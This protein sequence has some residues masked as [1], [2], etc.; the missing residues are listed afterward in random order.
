MRT[1]VLWD[2]DYTLL[3]CD[4]MGREAHEAAFARV[5]GRAPEALPYLGG[6][7]DRGV[8]T[9][10]LRAHGIE[11]EPGLVDRACEALAAEFAA[12]SGALSGRG[13]ALGGAA[14]ALDLLAADAGLVQTVLTG[15][16]RRIAAVKLA[17][18]GLD[19][20][21]DLEIGA[22]GDDDVDRAKLVGL[23]QARAAERH[24]EPFDAATTVVI[25]DTPN[26]VEAGRRGGAYTIA[27]ATGRN[28][29]EE[30]R[31]AGADVVLDDLAD[32]AALLAVLPRG[33]GEAGVSR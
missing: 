31:D 32:P 33:S 18:F 19:T 3:D 6:R 12:R 30:L 8:I 21:L 22:Y 13:R 20:H 2:V 26:D 9:G 4:G 7:T 16:L 25:G 17:A 23:A 27:V 11:P 14:A 5:T 29:A 15:N 1:L 28:P 24:G 10:V